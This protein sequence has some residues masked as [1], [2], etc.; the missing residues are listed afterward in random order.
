MPIALS[1]AAELL[2]RAAARDNREP[3]RA[4]AIAWSEDLHEYVSLADGSAAISAHYQRTRDWIMPSDINTA[5]RA[6]RKARTERIGADEIPPAA[7]D[8]KPA[9]AL[10]WTREY[11]RAI[12]DGEAPD[13]ATKRACDAV[14][15]AVPLQL[16]AVPRPEAVKRLMAAH[17]TG[18]LCGCLTKPIRPDEGTA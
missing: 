6:M 12:G 11:R 10:T 2:G 14:G 16:D 13:A 5:V 9:V 8:E 17:E 4:G 15:I 1:D 18:C 7:L 3:T